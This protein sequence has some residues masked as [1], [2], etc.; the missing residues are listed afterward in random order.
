M[1]K[2]V[3]LIA[4]TRFIDNK[5]AFYQ[6]RECIYFWES[7][8]KKIPDMVVK[9]SKELNRDRGEIFTNIQVF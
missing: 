1:I 8:S 7:K 5:T 4:Y 2:Y 9:L 3:T 6:R